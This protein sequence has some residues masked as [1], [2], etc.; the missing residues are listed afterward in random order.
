MSDFKFEGTTR[1]G[2]LVQ[3][4]ISANHYL[5]AKKRIRQFASKHRLKILHVKKRKTFLYKIQRNDEKPISGEQK[6]FSKEEGYL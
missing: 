5:Q 4:V 2:K 6:A 3:G 1:N